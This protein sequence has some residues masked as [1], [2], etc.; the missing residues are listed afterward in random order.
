[1]ER[2]TREDFKKILKFDI[3]FQ[4]LSLEESIKLYE[5]R[6]G[7]AKKLQDSKATKYAKKSV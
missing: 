3:D 2:G 4:S 6:Y 1:M 7:A 5:I